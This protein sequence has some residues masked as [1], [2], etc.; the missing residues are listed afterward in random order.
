[1]KRARRLVIC[2]RWP[3]ACLN[4]ENPENHRPR[5]MREVE[6]AILRPRMLLEEQ[7]L[8]IPN[9][10][11]NSPSRRLKAF[12]KHPRTLLNSAVRI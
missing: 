8:Q 5:P 9:R 6:E 3:Y 4:L 2:Q 10:I 1:M 12:M 7:K 11:K